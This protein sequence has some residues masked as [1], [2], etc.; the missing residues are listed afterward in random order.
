MPRPVDPDDDDP[1]L[2]DADLADP[3]DDSDEFDVG[4]ED[5]DPTAPCPHCGAWVYDDAERCPACERYLSR[6]EMRQ[7]SRPTWVVLT[8]VLLL[9][10][11]IWLA[12]F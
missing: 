4:D 6:E 2:A 11:M 5:D 3:D 12:V 9:A 1:W 7:P 8:A 10:G